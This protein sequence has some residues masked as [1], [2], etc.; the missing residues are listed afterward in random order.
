MT[1][2]VALEAATSRMS[3]SVC[4]GPRMCVCTGSSPVVSGSL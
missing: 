4:S 1:F 2:H 3:Q